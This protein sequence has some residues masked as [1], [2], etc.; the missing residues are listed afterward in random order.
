MNINIKSAKK[1][2]ADGQPG[3]HMTIIIRNNDSK[4]FVPNDPDNTDYQEL[5]AWV[6]EGN[7]IEEAD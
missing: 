3:D 6:A 2:V 4:V 7:V 5:L 1:M